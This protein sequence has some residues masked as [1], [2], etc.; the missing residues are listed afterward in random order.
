LLQIYAYSA[1]EHAKRYGS[2]KQHAAK[3]AYKN[4]FHSQYNPNAS[5]QK[6]LPME[7]ISSREIVH[8]ITLAM[9]ALT[10]DG[11][12]AAVVCSEEFMVE[13]KLQVCVRI[14][15]SVFNPNSNLS[16]LHS[17]MNRSLVV[18][19]VLFFLALKMPIAVYIYIYIYI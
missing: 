15:R 11:G 14:F 19:K 2:T 13:N 9:C 4:H 16:C 7:A 10:A 17:Y 12:A 5:L 6:V 3:I 8:P 1:R 18:P